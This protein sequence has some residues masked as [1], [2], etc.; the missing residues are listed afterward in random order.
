MYAGYVEPEFSLYTGAG[1]VEDQS[2]PGKLPGYLRTSA[3]NLFVLG[4]TGGF[5]YLIFR[6]MVSNVQKEFTFWSGLAALIASI[7]LSLLPIM[8]VVSI[9]STLN[10]ALGVENPYDI[11]SVYRDKFHRIAWFEPALL[12]FPI[13]SIAYFILI[14]AFNQAGNSLSGHQILETLLPSGMISLI[15]GIWSFDGKVSPIKE[16]LIRLIGIWSGIALGI[17]LASTTVT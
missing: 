1:I 7:L 15:L 13:W 8:I 5:F 3:E 4:L 17:W 14:L 9:L 12:M 6:W 10:K 11:L 16:S 2:D